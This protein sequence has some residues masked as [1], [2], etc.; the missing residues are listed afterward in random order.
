MLTWVPACVVVAERWGSGSCCLCV[1]PSPLYASHLPPSCASLC[2]LPLKVCYW[3]AETGRIFFE[4]VLPCIVIKPKIIWILLFGTVALGGGFVVFYEP[5]LRL[6]DSREFQLFD[7]DHPFEQ[8]ELT[9]KYE[10]WF[11]RN[12]RRDIVN[13]LPVRIVWGIKP[14]DNGDYQ[15]P[16]NKGTIVFDDEFDM[17]APSS[18]EWL[19]KFCRD[20]RKQKFYMSTLGPLLPNC[21]IE[22]FKTWMERRC[23][24]ST[25]GIN[26]YPCCDESKF[27][28]SRHVFKTCI[29]SSIKEL[30]QTPRQFFLPGVAGPKFKKDNGNVAAVVIEYD[31]TYLWSLSYEQMNKFYDEVSC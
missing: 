12:L 21:F 14:E 8:Y 24:D 13:R 31:S 23:L 6:P 18:Q 20:L 5:G 1:P 28:Y 17:S 25:S 19:L 3:F 30:Y 11:E 9:Y 22:T 2:A 7:R 4:K 29:H 16:A 15:N 27:P 26:R 10:F